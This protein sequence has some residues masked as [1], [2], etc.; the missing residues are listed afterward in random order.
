MNVAFRPDSGNP[1]VPKPTKG[2]LP[3][4]GGTPMVELTK[5]AAGPCRLFLKL[6]GANPGGSI[7]DRPALSMIEAAEREGRLEARRDD[8]RGDRRQH[9]PRP[10]AGRRRQGLPARSRHSRQDEPGEDLS[11]EGDGRGSRAD[12]LR[13]RQGPSGLLPGQGGPHR[14]RDAR[15]R[16]HQPVRQPG[17]S[18]RARAGHRTRDPRAARW[19]GRRGR[20]RR[21]LRRHADGPQPV[22]RQGVALDGD[23]ACRSGRLD[24][25]GRGRGQSAARRREAGSSRGSARTSFPDIA[26]LSRVSRAYA[27]DDAES[28]AAARALLKAEGALV[29]SSTGTALAAALKYCREQTGAEAGRGDL[30][31]QRQQISVEDVQRLLDGRPGLS[32]EAAARR[33]ARSHQP[34]PRRGRSGDGRARRQA[35]RRLRAHEALRRLAASGARKRPG[36][37]DHRR[38]RPAAGGLLESRA[39]PRRSPFRDVGRH[40]DRLRRQRR[41]AICFRSST[42]AMSPWWSTANGSSA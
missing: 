15:R 4:I 14:R 11:P 3:L 6:E 29:G 21:R 28:F 24:P 25:R 5:V 2:L 18:A 37:R 13:R 40:R 32:V 10:R 38:I 26:D 8:R 33:S 35:R 30:A 9:R 19:P 42:R 7:K 39:I 1:A 27:I 17:Q 41:S 23:R 36:R 12:A 31:G 34:P 16:L 22:L 20:L